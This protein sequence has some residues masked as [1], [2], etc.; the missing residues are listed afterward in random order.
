[1]ITQS[2]AL[3]KL[4]CA[5]PHSRSQCFVAAHSHRT[6]RDSPTSATASRPLQ[7]V[8]RNLQ[9]VLSRLRAKAALIS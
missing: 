2:T 8:L 9:V 6:C 3:Q 5:L 7:A 1:M 4:Q